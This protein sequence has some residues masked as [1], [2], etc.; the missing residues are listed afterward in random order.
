[1]SSWLH[2][3][4]FLCIG[5]FS[6]FCLIRSLSLSLA[7]CVRCFCVVR[8]WHWCQCLSLSLDC[9]ML[10]DSRQLLAT[11]K[12]VK[13]N[14]ASCS[15]ARDDTSVKRFET[16]LERDERKLV[17][18]NANWEP[19]YIY[20]C[21]RAPEVRWCVKVRYFYELSKHV[22][23]HHFVFVFNEQ[24]EK[25]VENV[26]LACMRCDRC[27]DGGFI[28]VMCLY[29]DTKHTHAFGKLMATITAA[30]GE[31]EEHKWTNQRVVAIMRREEW[32]A[33]SLSFASISPITNSI[34]TWIW[35]FL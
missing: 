17:Q 26:K 30:K 1:M 7:L 28:W 8:F 11:I 10:S 16:K 15:T 12:L 31:R 25:H 5:I 23:C 2:V 20:M 6:L 4:S 22:C 24:T 19:E 9:V 27:M 32:V 35:K 21:E 29:F 18:M 33:L 14:V 13:G 3:L 34:Y